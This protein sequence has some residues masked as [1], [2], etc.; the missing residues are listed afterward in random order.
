[1][2]WRKPWTPGAAHRSINGHAYRGV[3]V[4]LLAMEAME[5]GYASPFWIT[6]KQAKER[7]GSVRKGEKSTLIVFWKRLKVTEEGEEK[8]IPLLR[9]FRVFNIEQTEDVKL[10][11]AVADWTPPEPVA[12]LDAADQILNRYLADGPRLIESASEDAY[13]VPSKD[14]ITVPAK[15]RFANIE[16]FYSTAFHEVGHSTGHTSRLNRF[17]DTTFGSHG[18]GLEELAA[19]MTATMLCS[20]AGIESTTENSAA[21]LASWITTIKEDPK[22]L[23]KA[24]GQAQKAADLVLGRTFEKTEEVAA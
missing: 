20:E 12:G 15:G 2:P 21:Y 19:E 16:E 1:V 3:N 5:H 9:Y 24:A 10:P 8:I 11:A 7:G 6:F 18:Y 23:V 14:T 22:V 17:T 13:Y 4:F